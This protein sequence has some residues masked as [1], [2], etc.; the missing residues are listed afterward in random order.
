MKS[1][2]DYPKSVTFIDYKKLALIIATISVI[3]VLVIVFIKRRRK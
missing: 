3:I 1:I 2:D